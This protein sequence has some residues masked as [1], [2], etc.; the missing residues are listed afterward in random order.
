[1]VKSLR[2]PE[3][4]LVLALVA[5]LSWSSLARADESAGRA[6]AAEAPAA[7]ADADWIDGLLQ[8]FQALS[9]WVSGLFSHEERFVA[10][11]IAQFK[12]RVD[13]DLAAFDALV[14]Q[15]GFTIGSISVGASVVPDISLNLEFQRRLSEPEK[16]ALMAKINNPAAGIGTVERS[17][18]MTLLNAAESVYAVRGDGY[19]LSEVDIDLDVIPYVTFVMAPAGH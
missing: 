3:L 7:E 13:S 12:R 6:P 10:D 14:R 9:H 4:R 5:A 17:V 16:T 2:I 15:A 19:R 18:I 11:E 1:M 8:P